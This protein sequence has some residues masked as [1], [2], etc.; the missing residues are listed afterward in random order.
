MFLS[1]LSPDPDEIMISRLKQYSDDIQ[2]TQLFWTDHYDY[3][4]VFCESI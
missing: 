3:R 1:S 2:L 4:N